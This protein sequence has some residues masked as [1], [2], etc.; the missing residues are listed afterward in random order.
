MWIGHFY[1]TFPLL[2]V[3]LL[4]SH[5]LAAE[6]QKGAFTLQVEKRVAES[7][8]PALQKVFDVRPDRRQEEPEEYRPSDVALNVFV[9][10]TYE[11]SQPHGLLV[12]LSGESA[13]PRDWRA[14]LEERKLIWVGIPTSAPRD[15]LDAAA[16]AIDAVAALA[17]QYAIDRKRIH[18]GASARR[19]DVALQMGVAMPGVFGGV[20]AVNDAAYCNRIYGATSSGLRSYRE[21]FPKPPAFDRARRNLRIAFLVD[22]DAPA[23]GFLLRTIEDGYRKDGFTFKIIETHTTATPAADQFRE[24]LEAIDAAPAKPRAKKAEKPSP[25]APAEKSEAEKAP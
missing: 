15:D 19:A 18:V 4:A 3:F 2:V 7:S 16:M 13:A 20:I 24:A 23:E 1:R 9:P 14:V 11:K 22:Q 5:A 10:E 21:G 12:W 8:R 6:P 25:R 17:R